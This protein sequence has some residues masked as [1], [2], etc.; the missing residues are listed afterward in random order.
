MIRAIERATG[1][2]YRA[3][4]IEGGY[5]V[6][7]L[8]G[9]RYKKLKESTFL[10]YFK[11]IKEEEVKESDWE[12]PEVKTEEPT[13]EPQVEKKEK[14]QEK[15]KKQEKKSEPKVELSGEDRDN[16]VA[17]IKKILNLS[18]NN[19]SVEEG[20]SAVLQAQKL[21]AKYNISEDEVTL[22]EI[23]PDEIVSVY[24]HQLHN[25]HLRGWR[26]TLA[27]IVARNFRCN[28][29]M[30]GK[31]VVFRGYKTD[32]E[33]A[34]DAYN[35]LYAIGNRLASKKRRETKAEQGSGKGA[36][37]SFIYGYLQGIEEALGEQCTALMLVIPQEVKDE[38]AA[39][40]EANLKT[41]KHTTHFSK[42][43]NFEEGLVEGKNVVKSRQLEDKKKRKGGKK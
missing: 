43:K 40:S 13:P 35:Y 25:A 39:F 32:A 29:Y 7:T 3:K 30:D 42:N 1:N 41:R 15:T 4:K 26:K 27:T 20:M 18:K 6:L 28:A 22:E 9:E 37:A 34:L 11:R 10:R 33:V 21:M 12:E 8:S 36:H 24:T 2:E 16:M 17:K 31:D 14:K 19:P 38:Y 5:E 23:K